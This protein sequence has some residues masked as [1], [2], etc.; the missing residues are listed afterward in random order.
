[1]SRHLHRRHRL[2]RKT[3]RPLSQI[4][5]IEFLEDRRML[6]AWTAANGGSYLEASNWNPESV[7]GDTTDVSFALGN[8]Y[9]VTLDDVPGESVEANSVDID[10]GVVNFSVGTDFAIYNDL[11]IGNGASNAVMNASGAPIFL[12]PGEIAGG[13]HATR[14]IIKFYNNA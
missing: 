5:S 4:L 10:D 3:H 13:M 6:A 2:K 12:N 8:T 9:T 11:R 7:P 14:L 1:M